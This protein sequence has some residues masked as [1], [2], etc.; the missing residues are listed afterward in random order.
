MYLQTDLNFENNNKKIN[1]I[2]YLP[3]SHSE[4]NKPAI[5]LSHEFGSNKNNLKNYA[6]FFANNGYVAYIYDFENENELF[7]SSVLTESE[8]LNVVLENIYCLPF[9][10]KQKIYL[11]GS[12]QGG[13][14]STYVAAYNIDMI[15]GLI[16][17]CPAFVLQDEAKKR[18]NE[19]NENQNEFNIMGNIVSRKYNLDAVSFDIYEIMK[20]INKKVLII[21][22]ENDN[23][24]PFSYI[25]KA[26]KILNNCI[27]KIIKNANHSLNS[28]EIEEAKKY[29][30]EYLKK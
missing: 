16:L 14:V 11:F 24:V 10:D 27:L 6:E 17:Q 26:T 23:V 28:S 4:Q 9:I 7:D 19:L 12:S 8:T 15:S 20:N 21:C 1:G 29:I 2:L 13:F 5:I 22:G 30:L 25:E 18:L 3:S